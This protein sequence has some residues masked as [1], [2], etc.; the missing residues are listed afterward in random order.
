MMGVYLANT[1]TVMD[2]ATYASPPVLHQHGATGSR[3]RANPLCH[4]DTACSSFPN[5]SSGRVAWGE[6][7][8]VLAVLAGSR[9]LRRCCSLRPLRAQS[10]RRH[11]VR[12]GRVSSV[13]QVPAEIARPPYLLP[14]AEL[15]PDDGYPIHDFTEEIEIKTAKQ[16]ES[17]RMAC[18]LAR[19]ALL[20]AGRAAKPGATTDDIDAATHDFIISKGAYPSPLGYLDFPKSIST[21]VNDILAHGIP[22]DRQLE[23]GDI[24]NIDVTVFFDGHHGDTSCMFLVG[25]PDLEA[26]RLC[27]SGHD[28]MMAG[29]QA[30]GPGADFRG[31][32]YRIERVAR[33]SGF[34]VSPLFNGHGVGHYF[35]GAPQIIP[36][37]NDEDQGIMLPGM[38]FTVEP[39]LVEHDDDSWFD[40]SD[41]W[42][43]QT[44]TNSRAAQFEHTILITDVGHEILTGPSIYEQLYLQ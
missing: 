8:S 33:Q 30:C 19:E 38:I 41:G 20:L 34:H 7:A 23:D 31:I 3:A 17:M 15:D 12:P 5:G 1:G 6:T 24:L 26:R 43:V 4:S 9:N 22:D 10:V 40:W 27:Q 37:T 14:G 29:I 11:R 35:H 16:I 42:T 28:A 44:R 39:I 2:V 18:A 32:G 21:S 25:E 36:V 13:R